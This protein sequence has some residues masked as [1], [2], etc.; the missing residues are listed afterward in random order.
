MK[1]I[2]ARETS[3][4]IL[5]LDKIQEGFKKVLEAKDSLKVVLTP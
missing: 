5:P 1:K 3:T 4:H 2:N